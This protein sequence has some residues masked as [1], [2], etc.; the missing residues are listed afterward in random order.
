MDLES[1][2]RPVV[3]AA[4]PGKRVLTATPNDL[5]SQMPVIKLLATGG[6]GAPFRFDTTGIEVD[7]YAESKPESSALAWDAYHWFMEQLPPKIGHVGIMRV[8]STTLPIQT[9]YE[10]PDVSR[11]TFNVTIHTHDRGL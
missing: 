7:V 11:Y 3:T 10:N 5:V 4:F 6:S 2:L 8:E 9:S 1:G